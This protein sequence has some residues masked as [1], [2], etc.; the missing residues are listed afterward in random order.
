MAYM[1]GYIAVLI[2]FGAIDAVWLRFMG[3]VLYRPTLGDILLPDIRIAPAVAFY[4][5]YP[6]GLLAFAVFPGLKSGSAGAAFGSGVLLGAIAYATYDLTN[7]AT[8]RNWTLA[9]TVLDI[10][11]GAIASGLAALVAFLVVR[12]TTV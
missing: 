1:I 10:G 6:L 3:P 4:L 11:Y 2:S 5:I 9:I 12:A 8:L 7:F